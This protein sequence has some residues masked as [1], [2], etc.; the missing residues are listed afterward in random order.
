MWIILIVAA[1]LTATL[2]GQPTSLLG[3]V[4]LAASLAA[5]VHLEERTTTDAAH[6]A[7][8]RRVPM[9][10]PFWPMG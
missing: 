3:A 7:Y 10:V 1:V 4:L 2:F 8:R 6:R 5:K 9:F